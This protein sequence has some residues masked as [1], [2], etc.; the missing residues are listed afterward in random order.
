[1]S[2][3]ARSSFASHHFT[4]QNF[5]QIISYSAQLNLA[6]GR[7]V[8]FRIVNGVLSDAL[9]DL[10]KILHNYE[11]LASWVPEHWVNN[12]DVFKNSVC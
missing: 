7:F 3:G 6:Y 9:N 8:D 4:D 1:M 12:E 2:S 10:I 11:S 5:A